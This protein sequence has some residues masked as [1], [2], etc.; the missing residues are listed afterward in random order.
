MIPTVAV[1]A[2]EIFQSVRNI[3]ILATSREAMRVEGEHVYRL[4]SLRYPPVGE[5]LTAAEVMSFSAVHLFIERVSA[6]V[7][8]FHLSDRD[9]PA[10][11]EICARFDGIPL[12]IEIAAGRVAAFGIQET[13]TMLTGRLGLIWQGRRTA[14]PRHRSLN[15]ALD[16]SYGLLS[17]SGRRILQNLSVFV[18]TFT[19]EAAQAVVSDGEVE[20]ADVADAIMNLVSK[21]LI[22][23]AEGAPTGR[24][25]LLQTTRAYAQDRLAET[26]DMNAVAKRHAGY[27]TRLLCRLNEDSNISSIADAFAVY[28]EHLGNVRAGLQWSFSSPATPNLPLRFQHNPD[29]CL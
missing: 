23:S 1:L 28:G 20:G 22:S 19:R 26:G 2:E 3:S 8:G 12:A 5:R 27:F 11:A 4:P 13:A 10:V 21:S 14:P 25:H 6:T 18:G 17:D 9:A 29:I 7:N 16:W 15:A 24:F